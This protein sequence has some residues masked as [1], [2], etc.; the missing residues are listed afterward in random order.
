MPIEKKTANNRPDLGLTQKDLSP[1][2]KNIV[3]LLTAELAKVKEDFESKLEEMKT[4]FMLLLN[5]KNEKIAELENEN[6]SLRESVTKLENL[7]DDADAYERRDTLI[8]SGPAIPIHQQGELAPQVVKSLVASEF[9][10]N[11]NEADISTAHRIG[12][13]PSTQ[14]EDRRG[15]I[16]KFCRRDVKHSIIMASKQNRERRIFAN[17]SITPLRRTIFNTLRQI[18]RSHPDLVQGVSTYDGRV[19]AYTPPDSTSSGT[20]R[21]KRHLVNTHSGLVEFCQNYVKKPLELFLNSW[22]H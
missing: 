3:R 6:K 7:V 9:R 21:S 16:V 5:G 19:F 1:D 8:L 20:A 15:I 22:P 10:I 13:V 12:K 17:E 4:E 18:K 14:A 11:V 2:G